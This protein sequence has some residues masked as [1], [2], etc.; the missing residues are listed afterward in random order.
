MSAH[1]MMTKLNR[2][3]GLARL[4]TTNAAEVL[5]K[6]RQDP[7]A[8]MRLAGKEPDP[9][10]AELLASDAARML[11]LASRQAGK[12]EVA[13]INPFACDS[14]SFE[15]SQL[16]IS[17]TPL[18][19]PAPGTNFDATAATAPGNALINPLTI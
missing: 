7:S 14:V 11:L 5:D 1:A 6:L 15:N 9:W 10:Q 3:E 16:K 17:Y 2:L 8:I 19:Q 18:T 4:R 12:S 13:V